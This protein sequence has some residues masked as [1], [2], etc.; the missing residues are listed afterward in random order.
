V[1]WVSFVVVL[2]AVVL[3]TGVYVTWVYAPAVGLTVAGFYGLGSLGLLLMWRSHKH[4][5][6]PD[7]RKAYVNLL[8]GCM[9]ILVSWWMLEVMLRQ[10]RML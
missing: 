8:L 6:N 4:L 1:N 3:L 9:L 10:T 2:V 7:P 5:K